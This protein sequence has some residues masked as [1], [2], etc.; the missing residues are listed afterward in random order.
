MDVALLV[1]YAHLALYSST[2]RLVVF[3][4]ILPGSSRIAILELQNRLQ[5]QAGILRQ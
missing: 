4:P 2:A 1:E 5:Y 3:G